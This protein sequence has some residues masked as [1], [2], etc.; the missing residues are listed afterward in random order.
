MSPDPPALQRGAEGGSAD[1][2]L[3]ERRRCVE[4]RRQRRALETPPARRAPAHGAGATLR[5]RKLDAAAPWRVREHWRSRPGK[6]RPPRVTA[7]PTRGAAL[8]Q[9]SS[10]RRALGPCEPAAPLRPGSGRGLPVV[11]G[12]QLLTCAG[13]EN[14][15]V[16]W[17]LA[18]QGGPSPSGRARFAQP[19]ARCCW[20]PGS[21]ERAGQ[22]AQKVAAWG[23]AASPHRSVSAGELGFFATTGA[24]QAP[25]RVASSWAGGGGGFM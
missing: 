13:S 24:W 7:R 4:D 25:D 19:P 6:V 12:R 17:W 14:R 15:R 20:A 3:L 11:R 21:K 18:Q 9:D 16:P 22:L 10:G 2:P 1:V 8:Q 5:R 23:Q